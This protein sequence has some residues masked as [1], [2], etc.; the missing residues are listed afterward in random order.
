VI[1]VLTEIS[2]APESD[3]KMRALVAGV[4]QFCR[5]FEGCERF[6]LSFPLNR[7]GTLLSTEIWRD[8]QTLRAHAG[9]A[10]DAPEL[11]SWHE[12]VTR[13]DASIF[14]ASAV[15]LAALQT[16]DEGR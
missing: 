16:G 15:D 5:R 4:E 2:Y 12:L 13:I 8:R 14:A 1:I 3:A 7:P 6:A 9:V 11:T 10:H